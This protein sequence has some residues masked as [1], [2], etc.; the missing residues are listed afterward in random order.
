MVQEG[1]TRTETESCA[2]EIPHAR[3]QRRC[4]ERPKGKAEIKI[5]MD[6]REK[7]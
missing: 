4:D 7:K 1:C 5:R 3:A 6:P 2:I